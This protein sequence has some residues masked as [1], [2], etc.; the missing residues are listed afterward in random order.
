MKNIFN[1]LPSNNK[2]YKWYVSICQAALTRTLPKHIY[3][4]VHHILPKSIYP[5]YTKTP[6]NLVI[7]TAREHFICHWLLTKIIIDSRTIYAF[8]MMIPN[9]TSKR[10]RPKSSIVYSKL[11]AIFAKNNH[12]TSGKCWVTN[13]TTNKMIDRDDKIPVGYYL[14]RTFTEQHKTQ[15]KGIPKTEEQKKKQSDAM[16]GKPGI[17]GDRNP[18]KRLEVRR[19][20]SASRLGKPASEETKLKMRMSKLGKKRNPMSEETKLKISLAKKRQVHK[21]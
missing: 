20:I 2:Y 14:G 4:E 1:K 3:T 19:K 7:L 21:P 8:S 17:S 13:G 5:E 6:E 10:Y 18:A 9:K 11:K 15:L 16:L 12:G